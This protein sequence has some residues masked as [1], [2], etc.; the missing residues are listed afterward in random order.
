MDSPT[1]AAATEGGSPFFKLYEIYLVR[2]VGGG[3]V[4]GWGWVWCQMVARAGPENERQTSAW[5]H[6]GGGRRVYVVLL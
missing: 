5:V 1:V 2:R 6:V 3:G 4:G